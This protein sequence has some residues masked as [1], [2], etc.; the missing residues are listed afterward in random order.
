[1]ET[2]IRTGRAILAAGCLVLLLTSCGNASTQQQNGKDSVAVGKTDPAY[3][4]VHDISLCSRLYTTECHL[5][6]IVVYDDRTE[7]YVSGHELFGKP[8]DRKIAIPIDAT[9]K[10]YIDFSNFSDNNVRIGA[11]SSL[12][13]I[14]PDPKIELTASKIDHT[15]EREFTS[16]YRE[17]FSEEEKQ[18]YAKQGLDHII[19]VLPQQKIIEHS[20][21]SATHLLIPILKKMGYK[22]DRITI[23]FRDGINDAN[24][25]NPDMRPLIEVTN[26]Q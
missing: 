8:G 2:I 7:V 25:T 4:V 19:K 24:L 1:M 12:H 10:A 17:K 5:H 11:D 26:E 3:D 21:L 18:K 15:G 23:E 14:L 9:V 16:F 6:K 13:I 20:R 22:E